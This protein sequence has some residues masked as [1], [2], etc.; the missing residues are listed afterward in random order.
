MI[1]LEGF[2]SDITEIKNNE[3]ALKI[4]K[5][6]AEES[7]RLKSA[8]LANMSHEIRTPM[9]GI[10]GFSQLLKNPDI[11]DV[12]RQEFTDIIIESGNQLLNIV[13]D[14]LRISN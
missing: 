1:A 13:D 9:N 5:Q 8:F 14:I 2:I 3:Q 4:A 10:L 6:K 11:Y 7:D 12:K